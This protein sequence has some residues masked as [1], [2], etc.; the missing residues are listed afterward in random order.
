[1]R[2]PFGEALRLR[3][4]AVNM[5]QRELGDAV[6]ADQTTI[7]KWEHGSRPP[8]DKVALAR[9]AD[10]LDTTAEDLAQGVVPRE[11]RLDT[12]L[13]TDIVP[14]WAARA[15]RRLGA[16]LNDEDWRQAVAYLEGKADTRRLSTDRDVSSDLG[17]E[18]D[19]GPRQLR[20][21]PVK[22]R[23]GAENVEDDRL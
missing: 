15:I 14:T 11:I 3:R 13:P 18:D 9:L 1:M 16:L 12:E 22:S 5:T 4:K 23:M 7:A 10:V 21:E 19:S 6:G 17:D 8:R 20:N 2:L